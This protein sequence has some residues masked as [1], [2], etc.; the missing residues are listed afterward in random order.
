MI[1]KYVGHFLTGLAAGNQNKKGTKGITT[2]FL[3]ENGFA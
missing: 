3:E 2:Q 1:G